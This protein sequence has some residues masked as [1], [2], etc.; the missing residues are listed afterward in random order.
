MSATL[1]HSSRWLGS[2]TLYEFNRGE[3]EVARYI[4]FG[5]RGVFAWRIHA[6]ALLPP[7]I[8]AIG[9][10]VRFAPP[11]QRFY[12]GGPNSVRGYGANELGPRVYVIKDSSRTNYD[13]LPNGDRVYRSIR[14]VAT[15]GNRCA[16]AE[17]RSRPGLSGPAGRVRGCGA[18]VQRRPNCTLPH[19]RV[20]PGVGLRVTTPL[21]PVR[22]DVAYNGYDLEP[23]TLLL[24]NDSTRTLVELPETYQRGRADS[25]WRRLLIQFAIGQAF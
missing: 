14:T 15:G 5:R 21:G 16:C 6:G 11:E 12:A 8:S 9:Q 3:I 25:F 4:P 2:D 10:S 22:V 13:T 1:L 19:V 23:G 18:G 17:V 7:R 20:T 24:Q